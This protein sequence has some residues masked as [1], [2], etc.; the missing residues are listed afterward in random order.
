VTDAIPDPQ[1]RQVERLAELLLEMDVDWRAAAENA[2]LFITTQL[3]VDRDNVGFL[4][5]DGCWWSIVQLSRSKVTNTASAPVWLVDSA[6]RSITGSWDEVF[7]D[8]DFLVTPDSR[9]VGTLWDGCFDDNAP[10]LHLDA[11]A[12]AGTISPYGE[13]S[14]W[15]VWADGE[16]R[17]IAI[18]GHTL[19][20]RS[21]GS[22]SPAIRR[23]SSCALID[24]GASGAGSPSDSRC[25]LAD[26]ATST[27]T[28]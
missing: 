8:P 23:G 27:T 1:P 7:S 12:W 18:E 13:A 14:G 26:Q 3:G 22:L 19:C 28:F 9:F 11:D 16:E 6:A 20:R 5:S 17:Q 2:T 15:T 25:S 24:S 4:S 21:N 10:P